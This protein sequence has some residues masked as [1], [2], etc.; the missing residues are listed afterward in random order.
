M[1]VLPNVI[2]CSAAISSCEKA[3]KWQHAVAL[4]QEMLEEELSPDVATQL[5]FGQFFVGA[6]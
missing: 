4:Y 5:T 3:Q 2:S 6:M 1:K